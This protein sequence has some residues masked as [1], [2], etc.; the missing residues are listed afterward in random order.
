[1]PNHSWTFV[2][3]RPG[4]Y[5]YHSEPHPWMHAEI[6]VLPGESMTVMPEG[7]IHP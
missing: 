3:D 1:M 7:P 6:I 5:W 2:F 4:I